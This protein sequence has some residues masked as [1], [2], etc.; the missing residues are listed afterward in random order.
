MTPC[1]RRTCEFVGAPIASP[2]RGNERKQSVPWRTRRVSTNAQWRQP[3]CPRNR[4]RSNT[5][6]TTTYDVITIRFRVLA[7]DLYANRSR[8]RRFVSGTTNKTARP[9]DGASVIS[10][11]HRTRVHSRICTLRLSTAFVRNTRR[12]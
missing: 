7:F 10:V 6:A 11:R 3:T 12:R 2:P 5:Y 8:G 1:C 9:D 4:L